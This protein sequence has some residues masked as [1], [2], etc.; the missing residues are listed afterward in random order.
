MTK[1][2]DLSSLSLAFVEG[3]YA[4][5]CRDPN[6]VPA[7]WR[8]HFDTLATNGSGLQELKLG[9]TTAIAV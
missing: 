7:A 9:P 4:D 1:M 6:S 3:L 5:Y 2:A 8:T